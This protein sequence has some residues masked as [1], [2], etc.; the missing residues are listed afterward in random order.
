VIEPIL[1]PHVTRAPVTTVIGNK[2]KPAG[3]SLAFTVS[4]TDADGTPLTYSASSIPAS[5]TFNPTSRTFAWTPTS[6]QSGTSMV[7][8]FA[9]PMGVFSIRQITERGCV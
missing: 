4:A 7:A 6:A 5:A 1:P 8:G 9:R 2:A 3:S